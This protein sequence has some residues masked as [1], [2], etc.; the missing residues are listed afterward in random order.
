MMHKVVGILVVFVVVSVVGVGYIKLKEAGKM[1][2]K[3]QGPEAI[4]ERTENRT[5]PSGN[6][7][8]SVHSVPESVET[9]LDCDATHW[10]GYDNQEYG[11]TLSCPPGWRIRT[12]KYVSEAQILISKKD[13]GAEFYIFPVGGFGHGFPFEYE[14]FKRTLGGRNALM[15]VFKRDD[16]QYYAIAELKGELPVNWDKNN[17]IELLG[18]DPGNKALLLQILESM[19]FSSQP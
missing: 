2:G 3:G 14:E 8:P 9:S 17:R 16:D 7:L 18:R 19:T 5:T 12:Q 10:Q 1:G 13:R 15:T 4:E 6:E 11:F